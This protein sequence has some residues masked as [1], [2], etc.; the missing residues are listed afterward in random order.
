MD[1]MGYGLTFLDF[2]QVDILL[3]QLLGGLYGVF[4]VGNQDAEKASNPLVGSSKKTKGG[5][6]T[7]PWLAVYLVVILGRYT[8]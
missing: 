6:C 1:P 7:T 2:D 4:L 8:P 5:E 3:Y